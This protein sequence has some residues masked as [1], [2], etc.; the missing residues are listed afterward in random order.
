MTTGTG[1]GVNVWWTVPETVVD[2]AVAQALLAKHG[3]EPTDMKL[4]SRHLEVSRAVHSFH[5]RRRKT[6]RRLGE[7]VKETSD[8]AIFGILEREQEGEQVA[9][10][11]QTK[12]ILDKSTGDVSVD[13]RLKDDVLNALEKYHGKITDEDIRYFLRRVIRM[14]YGVAKSPNG[15]IYFV[16]GKCV[17]VIDQAQTML[18][19][20][21]T[22]C[23]IF[24]EEI[25][26]GV[27]ERSNVW[28]SVED[29]VSDRVAKV[30][31]KIG[32]IE[33][34]SSIQ[35]KKAEIEKA[36]GLMSLY[37]QL[38]GEEAKY[39]ALAEKIEGAVRLV[40][41]KI[42]TIQTGVK[43]KVKVKP[44][45]Q[46]V[47][48]ATVLPATVPE[49]EPATVLPVPVP[50]S[51]SAPV[52]TVKTGSIIEATIAVL[53]KAGKPM[54]YRDIVDEAIRQGLYVAKAAFPYMAFHGTMMKALSRGEGRFH[55]IGRGIY[56]VAA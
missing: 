50:A 48:T 54:L 28:C 53:S 9:F 12:V 51:G 37:K 23:H 11:Q 25:L 26:N 34:L 39:E 43:V 22:G 38:L 21:G 2:G 20:M 31:A 30:V 15:G 7:K 49:P 45:S 24:M 13:G 44:Q 40:S 14:S 16:P 4:P 18:N 32:Q 5:N 55:K 46:M 27:Q 3:F 41:E 10:E 36:A 6:E 52:K 1:L 47:A 17:M 33:R 8:S 35:G 56:E 29:D 42:T 19:E